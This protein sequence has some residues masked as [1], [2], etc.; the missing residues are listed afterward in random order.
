MVKKEL[1]KFWFNN[2]LKRQNYIIVTLEF[3]IA[4]LTLYT[5]LMAVRDIVGPTA[6]LFESMDNLFH[7]IVMAVD[8]QY[9]KSNVSFSDP[10]SLNL[11]KLLRG[12]TPTLIFIHLLVIVFN[13]ICIVLASICRADYFMKVSIIVMGFLLFADAGVFLTLI[14]INRKT[15]MY[16]FI[17]E[18]ELVQTEY[19]GAETNNFP[20]LLFNYIQQHLECCGIYTYTEW[21]NPSINWKRE[22]TYNNVTYEIDLPISCCPDLNRTHPPSCAQVEICGHPF[23]QGC[24]EMLLQHSFFHTTSI[25][26]RLYTLLY[27]VS[28]ILTVTLYI[29]KINLSERKNENQ[30]LF[31]EGRLFEDGKAT[32]ETVAEE[33]EELIRGAGTSRRITGF[34]SQ[35]KITHKSDSYM[36]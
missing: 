28:H 27:F 29:I 24:G 2:W 30:S 11:Y 6:L 3:A 19:L 4:I 9:V 1:S 21:L 13:S 17:R 5:L 31:Y 22:V 12:P 10:E 8:K 26:E 34:I 23:F 20:T 14:Y 18:L 32:N 35:K 15:H 33:P 25:P 7:S 16:S 36:Y